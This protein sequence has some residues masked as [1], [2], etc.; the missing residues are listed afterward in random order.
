MSPFVCSTSRWKW[1]Y[2]SPCS[3]SN[4]VFEQGIFVSVLY[5]FLST[6]VRDAIRRQYRR[7]AARRSANSVRRNAR[8]NRSSKYGNG[9]SFCLGTTPGEQRAALFIAPTHFRSKFKGRAESS[10]SQPSK[11][12][13]PETMNNILPP[14][15]TPSPPSVNGNDAMPVTT[16]SSTPFG[17]GSGRQVSIPLKD[18]NNILKKNWEHVNFTLSTYP[19]LS[20]LHYFWE[21]RVSGMCSYVKLI[22]L[23]YFQYSADTEGSLERKLDWGEGRAKRKYWNLFL[24]I[25]SVSGFDAFSFLVNFWVKI[26]LQHVTYAGDIASIS[27]S[28]VVTYC[29]KGKGWLFF[30]TNQIQWTTSQLLTWISTLINVNSQY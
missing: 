23:K 15:Q 16:K 27:R 20:F 26:T 11:S 25:I 8:N 3:H 7:F 19:S 10:R 4:S 30:W 5:C 29:M 28:C 1:F 22:E 6:D 18:F 14:S 12:P 9:E 2:F 21:K 13:S 17:R 24:G